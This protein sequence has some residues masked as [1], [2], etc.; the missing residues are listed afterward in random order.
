MRKSIL[1]M[2]AITAISALVISGCNQ[3]PSGTETTEKPKMTDSDL[4]GRIKARLNEDPQLRA[5]DLGV[6]CDVDRNEVRLSGTVGSEALRTRAVEIARDARPGIMITD[7]IDVKPT[8]LSRADYTDER[9]SEERMRAKERGETIGQSTEDA[10]VH[11]KIVAKMIGNSAT[12]SRNINVDVDNGV[13]TLRGTV[14]SAEAKTE[15]GR[16][17][18]DTDGV[19]R[20]NNLI[21]V[22]RKS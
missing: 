7:K 15:A 14:E 10:W 4:E 3:P 11:S 5:A 2:L 18:K 16:V 8:E 12:P 6:K 21:K 9:A 13:V 17:A 19:K 22:G 1:T 20:V